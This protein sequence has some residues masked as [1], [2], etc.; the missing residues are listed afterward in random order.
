MNSVQASASSWIFITISWSGWAFIR[1]EAL[2]I[3]IPTISVQS[4]FKRPLLQPL[5]LQIHRHHLLQLSHVPQRGLSFGRGSV[6]GD[7]AFH[8]LH[9][10]FLMSVSRQSTTL[11][12]FMFQEYTICVL[13][14]HLPHRLRESGA[15]SGPLI[16][17]DPY[18]ERN[19]TTEKQ[20]WL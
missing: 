6:P 20:P 1:I 8:P 17:C 3:S 19:A 14:A 18:Q 7:R 2:M 9:G 5:I 4:V 10:P 12:K 16:S 15:K 13:F 11:W